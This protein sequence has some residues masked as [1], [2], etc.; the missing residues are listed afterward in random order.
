[1]RIKK[2]LSSALLAVGILFAAAPARAGIPVFD[3]AAFAQHPAP[4][5]AA[6]EQVRSR[7]DGSIAPA[8]RRKQAERHRVADYPRLLQRVGGDAK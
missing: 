5:G 3:S 7:A 1:M 8:Q 2:Y 4:G 6:V